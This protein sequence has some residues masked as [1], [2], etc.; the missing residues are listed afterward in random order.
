MLGVEASDA[1]VDLPSLLLVDPPGWYPFRQTVGVRLGGP[2][3]LQEV[4]VVISAEQQRQIVQV[5]EPTKNPQPLLRPGLGRL[6][7]RGE[8]QHHQKPG[9]GRGTVGSRQIGGLSVDDQSVVDQ[10]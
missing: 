3:L 8:L 10:W 7:P 6:P 5:S 4:G 1:G 9:Q 2:A